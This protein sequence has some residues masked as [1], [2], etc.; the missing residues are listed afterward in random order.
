MKN[1]DEV[2][3]LRICMLEDTTY[4]NQSVYYMF[5]FSSFEIILVCTAGSNPKWK[6]DT[7]GIDIVM[8][9]AMT[10][11][12]NTIVVHNK[13]TLKTYCWFF[14]IQPLEASGRFFSIDL[15]LIEQSQLSRWLASRFTNVDSHF[16]YTAL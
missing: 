1:E 7:M 3:F 14:W 9:F 2:L 15:S 4:H 11:L 13:W 8:L 12:K 5:W 16:L 6:H 10:G